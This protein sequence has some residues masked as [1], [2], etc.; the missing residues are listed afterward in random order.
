MA[1]PRPCSAWN[2]RRARCGYSVNIVSVKALDRVWVEDAIDRLRQQMVAGVIAISPQAVLGDAFGAL[3]AELPVVVI[4][5]PLRSCMP[6]ISEAAGAAAATRHLLDLGHRSH[7]PGLFQSGRF[8]GAV[9]LCRS[10]CSP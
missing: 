8:R 3:P 5:G 6:A 9:G 1:L 7:S 2:R 4:W 10:P